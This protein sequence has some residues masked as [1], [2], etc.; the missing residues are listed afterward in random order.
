M[1]IRCKKLLDDL[2]IE[3]KDIYRKDKDVYWDW[4][5]AGWASLDFSNM[6]YALPA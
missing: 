1:T 2:L 4:S 5:I 3:A 6:I